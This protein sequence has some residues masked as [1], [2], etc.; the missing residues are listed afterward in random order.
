[1]N[2]NK[3]ILIIETSACGKFQIF[4]LF[5]R[6]MTQ[7]DSVTFFSMVN[8]VKWVFC[9]LKKKWILTCFMQILI[10]RFQIVLISSMYSQLQNKW[11]GIWA[12]H[13]LVVFGCSRQLICG[14][15]FQNDSLDCTYCV[16]LKKKRIMPSGL[17]CIWRVS[18]SEKRLTQFIAIK[19]YLPD[20]CYILRVTGIPLK[21]VAYKE[22]YPLL[23]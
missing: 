9:D 12:E 3:V 22:W 18:L 15:V 21:R 19:S 4:I 23:D 16:K 8:S 1:M 6:H 13:W 14:N 2:C 11:K 10:S 20:F 5:F 17:C 7:Y